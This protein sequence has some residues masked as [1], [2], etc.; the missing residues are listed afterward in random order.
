MT[1]F[2]LEC[3]T[4]QLAGALAAL[5]TVYSQNAKSSLPILLS[6]RL[7]VIDGR[8]D[9]IAT[10]LDQSV[11]CGIAA[12]GAGAIHLDTASLAARIRALNKELPVTIEG[13]GTGV[14]IAQKRTKWRLP[15]MQS[16]PDM[17]DTYTKVT[18]RLKGDV[19]AIRAD[20]LTAALAATMPA[21][22]NEVTRYYLNGPYIET[23][24][25][26][27]LRFVATDGHVLACVQVPGQWPLLPG[28]FLM[29]AESAAVIQRLYRDD[30]ELTVTVAKDA[31]TVDDGDTLFRSKFIEGTYPDWRRVVPKAIV[32]EATVDA[33]ALAAATARVALISED[34]GQK[35]GRF[36]HTNVSIGDGELV[37]TTKNKKGEASED[38][39]EC[40]LA[41][42]D[43]V[44]LVINARHLNRIIGSFGEVDTLRL[45]WCEDVTKLPITIRRE[46]AG[47]DD[48]RLCMPLLG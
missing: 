28:H 35:S 43:G 47:V 31:F 24:K 7:E 6:T 5:E 44:S 23:D 26:G 48:Y 2:A 17:G 37:L 21:V 16:G 36:I 41:Q 18:A 33:E 39:V 15:A 12:E 30:R 10:N 9:F 46:G 29:P 27:A 22:S 3:M 14:T 45:G 20:Y 8:A 11:H 4:D 34:T 38:V 1:G 19:F 32:G 25:G 13:D 40:G 42:A